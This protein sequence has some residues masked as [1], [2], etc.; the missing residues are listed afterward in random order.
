MIQKAN[1]GD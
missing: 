1:E